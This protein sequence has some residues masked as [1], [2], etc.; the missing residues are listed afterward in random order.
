[1]NY[2]LQEILTFYLYKK[3]SYEISIPV[4]NLINPKFLLKKNILFILL[5]DYKQGYFIKNIPQDVLDSIKMEKCYLTE[6]LNN[7]P[8]QHQI[9]LYP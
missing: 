2:N 4:Q 6:S 3:D 1:M 8:I 9:I 5:Y 7:E